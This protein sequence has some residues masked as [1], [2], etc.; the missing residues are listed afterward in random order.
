MLF[1]FSWNGI[2]MEM[3]IEIAQGIFQEAKDQGLIAWIATVAGIVYLILAARNNILCWPWGIVSCSLWAYTTY[4]DYDLYLDAI[5]QLFYVFMAFV[6][7][8]QWKFGGGEQERLAVSTMPFRKH[9][10]L[11]FLGSLCSVLFGYFFATYTPAAATYL[12]AFTTVFSVI[13]TFLLVRRILDNWIY[14]IVVDAIY[15]YLYGS[16]GAY[17]FALLMVWYVYVATKAY[18]IWKKE[19]QTKNG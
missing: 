7:I 1:L 8:Y 19:W 6:G 12:D 13:A 15:I 18:F 14:W 9:L 17:L 11:L 16:R 3:V 4:W 5:L 2:G 10:P